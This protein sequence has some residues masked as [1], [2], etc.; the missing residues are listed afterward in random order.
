M[1]KLDLIEAHTLNNLKVTPL[2]VD[3]NDK[4]YLVNLIRAIQGVLG[5]EES[6]EALIEVARNAH[7]AVCWLRL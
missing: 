6:G 5:T 2:S 3:L 4:L 7:R 1:S